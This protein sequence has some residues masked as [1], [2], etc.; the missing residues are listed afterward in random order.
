MSSNPV[1]RILDQSLERPLKP[2][3]HSRLT[4]S[5]N[6]WKKQDAPNPGEAALIRE[7]ELLREELKHC[8]AVLKKYDINEHMD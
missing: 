7:V 8:R 3:E 6:A 4:A 5:I 1:Q 2:E